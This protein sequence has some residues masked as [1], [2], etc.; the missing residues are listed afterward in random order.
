M[1]VYF[2]SKFAEIHD[3]NDIK[4]WKYIH[5]SWINRNYIFSCVFHIL[6]QSKNLFILLLCFHENLLK[7]R[8]S[9]NNT[10]RDSSLQEDYFSSSVIWP[11]LNTKIF[12]KSNSKRKNYKNSFQKIICLFNTGNEKYSQICLW[13]T[14][15]VSKKVSAIT[16][17]PLYKVFEFFGP[18]RQQK[19]RWRVFSYD[20]G[21][22]YK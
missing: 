7:A 22:H 8:V 11:S 3:N 18:K 13:W 6:L 19:L 16:R 20:S 1:K 2:L 12:V 15:A 4:D 9:W 14:P 10:I 21:K 5:G 17:C